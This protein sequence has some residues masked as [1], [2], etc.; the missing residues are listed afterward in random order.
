M[1]QHRCLQVQKMTVIGV[2]M[3]EQSEMII[4]RKLFVVKKGKE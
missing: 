2:Q 4:F 3:F 1:G